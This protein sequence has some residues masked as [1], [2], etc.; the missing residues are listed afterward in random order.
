MFTV[1][2]DTLLRPFNNEIIFSRD[3]Y[4]LFWDKQ[5]ET[6]ILTAEIFA[7]LPG[8]S[9]PV[10]FAISQFEINDKEG[11]IRYGFFAE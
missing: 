1:L 10:P 3:F 9:G 4:K 7:K 6:L 8:K 5:R 2:Q 11:K